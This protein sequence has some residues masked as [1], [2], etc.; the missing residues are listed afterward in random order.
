MCLLDY[1]IDF[2]IPILYGELFEKYML[3]FA[4]EFVLVSST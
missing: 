3:L 4:S 1:H 2:T